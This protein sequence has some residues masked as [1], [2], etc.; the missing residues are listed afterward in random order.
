MNSMQAGIPKRE[1]CDSCAHLR[2]CIRAQRIVVFELSLVIK[3]GR[4][5]KL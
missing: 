5:Q 3:K 4:I 1:M 2:I